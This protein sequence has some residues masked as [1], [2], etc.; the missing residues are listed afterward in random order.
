MV[1]IRGE[2]VSPHFKKQIW[3][4]TQILVT[5]TPIAKHINTKVYLQE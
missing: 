5:L 1:V 3:G 2:N 4:S